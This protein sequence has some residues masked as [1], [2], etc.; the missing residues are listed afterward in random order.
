[1]AAAE[2]AANATAAS[3]WAALEAAM[4]TDESARETAEAARIVIEATRTDVTDSSGHSDRADLE[5]S[6]ARD[7]YQAAVDE[8]ERRPPPDD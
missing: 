1:V 5:E 8:A 2:K 3:A 4:S 7:A 6:S